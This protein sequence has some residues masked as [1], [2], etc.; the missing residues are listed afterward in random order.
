MKRIMTLGA[1]VASVVGLLLVMSPSRGRQSGVVRKVHADGGCS[2]ATLKGPYGFFRTGATAGGPLAA[3][4]IVT[5]DGNGSDTAGQT[6]RKNGVT[7]SDLFADPPLES[8]YE[9]DPDCTGRFLFDDGTVFGHFVIVDGGKE[10]FGISLSTGNSVTGVWKKI[11]S[12]Q[13]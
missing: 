8:L 5:F 1:V 11:S 13:E 10:L 9:V 12:E 3:V 6:V 7:T 2:V 4:G